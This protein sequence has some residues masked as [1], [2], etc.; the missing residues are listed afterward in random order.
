MYITTL[1]DNNQYIIL[2]LYV[3]DI[4]LT[5]DAAEKTNGNIWYFVQFHLFFQTKY[6]IFALGNPSL[7]IGLQFQYTNEGIFIS[8]ERNAEQL[9]TNYNMCPSNKLRSQ[10]D[11]LT[12]NRQTCIPKF[13]S[14]AISSS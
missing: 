6:Q 13:G 9:L 8:Q 3:D 14:H 11:G 7:Y 2:I 10:I 4:M 12:R 5:G 1:T